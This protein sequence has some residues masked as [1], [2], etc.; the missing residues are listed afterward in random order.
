MPVRKEIRERKMRLPAVVPVV[1]ANS[2]VAS[3]VR[4]LTTAAD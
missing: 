3:V 1:A 2:W 4:V